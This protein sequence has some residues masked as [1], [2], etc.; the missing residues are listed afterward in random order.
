MKFKA[1]Q[2][3]NVTFVR[4]FFLNAGILKDGKSFELLLLGL[5]RLLLRLLSG[6]AGAD[7]FT[8]GPVI[9]K[10]GKSKWF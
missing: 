5:S 4:P 9:N 7:P 3:Q 10:T 1:D 8:I 6:A 2:S